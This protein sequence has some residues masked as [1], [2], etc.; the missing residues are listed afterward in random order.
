ML[1]PHNLIIFML[2]SQTKKSVTHYIPI[3]HLRLIIFETLSG[4]HLV[5]QT[6]FI[7]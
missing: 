4:G 5:G 7:V 3:I 6:A 1:E 2:T